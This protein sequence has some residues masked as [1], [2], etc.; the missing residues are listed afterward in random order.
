MTKGYIHSDQSLGTV[1][2]PGIRFVLFLQGCPL[3]CG[4]CHNPDTWNMK[5]YA[6]LAEP[7]YVA[8]KLLRYQN[9]FGAE[10]GI[11]VSGGEPLMQPEFVTELFEIV[12]AKQ[13]HTC[14]D[15]SGCIWNKEV[16]RLL[17]VTD[18]V[19]LDVKMTTEEAYQTY[20]KGSLEQTI[21]FLNHLEKM[22]KRTWIRHVVVPGF[23]D[24][25]EDLERF[26]RLIEGFSCIEKV[27]L[28]PFRKICKEKYEQMGIKFPF[29]QYEEADSVTSYL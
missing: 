19:L 9:Y 11:T 7:E 2:G 4:Y 18:M 28:L 26:Y 6:E 5:D 24:D 12:Q 8:K 29:E 22:G 20:V 27:E 25:K 1:D 10:G 23:N 16:E 14:L 3:R 21:A 17:S 13:I 15:T